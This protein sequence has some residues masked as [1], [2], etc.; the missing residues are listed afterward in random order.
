M[1]DLT[2]EQLEQLSVRGAH[3]HIHLNACPERS[4]RT[5]P[6]AQLPD[7]APSEAEG[8]TRSDAQQ[9][10]E[11]RYTGVKQRLRTWL[12]DRV[13]GAANFEG[14]LKLN[15]KGLMI[16]LQQPQNRSFQPTEKFWVR[17]APRP[18]IIFADS[19]GPSREFCYVVLAP[20][21]PDLNGYY[22]RA[23]EVGQT[24]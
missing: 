18:E 7:P 19:D 16:M 3:I 4:E 13:G 12:P 20:A 21:S 1:L 11:V 14:D 6:A 10:V 24:G 15:K 22:V 5:T 9:N 2:Y 17:G 8:E 23:E